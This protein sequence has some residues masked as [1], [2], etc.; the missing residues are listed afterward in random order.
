MPIAIRLDLRLLLSSLLLFLATSHIG[1]AAVILDPAVA[2]VDISQSGEIYEDRSGQLS[3]D[4]LL[5]PTFQRSFRPLE[6]GDLMLDGSTQTYWLLFRFRNTHNETLRRILELRPAHLGEVTVYA[7]R[8]GTPAEERATV[9]PPQDMLRPQRIYRLNLPAGSATNIYVRIDKHADIRVSAKLFSDIAFI[10]ESSQ[11]DIGNFF[12]LGVL[13]TVSIYCLVAFLIYREPLFANLCIFGVLV[14][15][16]QLMAWGYLG[17]PRGMLPPWDSP[18][19]IISAIGILLTEVIFALGFP[20]YPKQRPGHW[21]NILRG[22]LFLLVA[23]L[24]FSIITDAHYSGI[25]LS[26]LVPLTAAST[27]FAGLNGYFVS[28]SRL[29]LFYLL[30]KSL[31][32]VI[33][34]LAQLSYLLGVLDIYD[35]NAL[36]SLAAVIVALAHATLLITRSRKRWRMQHEDAQRIAVVDEVNRAKSEV[37]ARITHD[38]RTPISAMLGVTELLQETQL[39][40]SQEDY[41][42]SL[43]R[44][45][46]ELLQLLEEAGQAARFSDSDIDLNSQLIA[47]P[48]LVS[49]ALSSF[50]NMAAERDLELISDLSNTLPMQLLG[51]LSRLRQLLIHSLNSAFEHAEGG[52]IL[53][54]IGPASPRPGHLQ[55]EVSHRGSNFTGDERQALQRPKVDKKDSAMS[56]RFAIIARLVSLMGGQISLRSSASRDVHALC[57]TLQLG[58][59]SNKLPSPEATDLLNNKRLLVVD[60]NRT[61][62]EVVNK[63]CSPWGMGVFS[64]TNEQAALAIMRNQRLINAPVDFVLI[65]HRQSDNGLLLARRV[66][67]EFANAGHQPSVLLLAHANI[68][69]RREELQAAG[70]QR[71][72]SKPLGNIA[73]R[74]AL[75]GESRV[76]E[77][78]HD[79]DQYSSDA[80]NY[81]SLRCLI[82]EDNPSNALVLSR[83]LK[84]LGITVQHAENGQQALNF[85]IRDHYDLVILDVEMPVM[86]GIE[87]ARQIRQF[88]QEEERERTPIFGLTAN[89]LDEQRDSYLNAGMDLHLVKPI[90][91]WELAESIQRWT[92]YQHQKD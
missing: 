4:D 82:A 65:D 11:R 19:M 54:K 87:A 1:H 86:D 41:L 31:T 49:D 42:R 80:L 30:G 7:H 23:A 58:V 9:F 72:L 45:S 13:S 69:Y 2:R 33:Y 28:Y 32:L 48:E 12:L 44:S 70:V 52:F 92:G 3:I 66:K 85:F 14:M 53:L 10:S 25:L 22:I 40:A 57:M 88:E 76:A 64:A 61:F 83:M 34:L 21:P 75:L 77:R 17:Q 39:T 74:S 62:C 50:R 51:D 47:L 71:V 16:S 20:V 37:L 56:T 73:L 67:E 36:L 59:I 15:G 63:Q 60:S 8:S 38:I 91:L 46:H 5:Q 18:I 78:G 43:Q 89:A 6:N 24:P 35:M 68:S 29:L 81:H 84:S 79:I 27:L 55:V 26:I 90:R